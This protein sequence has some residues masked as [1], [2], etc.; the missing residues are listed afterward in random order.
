MKR[1][2][3]LVAAVVAAFTFTVQN[4]NAGG[5]GHLDKRIKAVEIGTG[6]AATAAYFAI[7]NWKWRWDNSSSLTSLGAYGAT[8]LGCA[9][10]APMVA[11]VVVNRPLTQ[12]EGH[13]L[14]GACVVPIVGGWLVNYAYNTHPEWEAGQAPVAHHHKKKAK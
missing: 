9:V 14:I 12:R 7:N 5:R 8:T 4:A 10:V 1:S 3:A 13:V 6:I 11:T 2:L